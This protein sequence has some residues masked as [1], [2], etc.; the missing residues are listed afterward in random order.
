MQEAIAE[1]VSK[2]ASDIASRR[3]DNDINSD[4]I[5]DTNGGDESLPKKSHLENK[6]DDNLES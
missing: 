1:W 2:L 5:G 6:N 3:F 4:S